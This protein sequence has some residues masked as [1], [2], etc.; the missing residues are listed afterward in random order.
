M[1]S[2]KKHDLALQAIEFRLEAW[3]RW[4]RIS[5][6]LPIQ[7]WN[8]SAILGRLIDEGWAALIHG[9]GFKPE[10]EYA[11]EER[12]EKAIDALPHYL[13]RVIVKNYLSMIPQR[14]KARELGLSIETY[15]DY[16]SISKHRVIAYVDGLKKSA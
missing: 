14:Y 8:D 4:K 5:G 1:S 9:Q 13:G 2:P 11:D 15:K 3:A 7:A 16:L 12:I 10:P 6:Q